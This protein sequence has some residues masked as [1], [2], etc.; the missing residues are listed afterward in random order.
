MQTHNV[1]WQVSLSNGETL[2]EDPQFGW[3]EL[4]KY[5]AQKDAT[6]T[7]LTLLADGRTFNLPSAGNN[8]KFK[9]FTDAPKPL[10]YRVSRAIGT[11]Y[12]N[13]GG[14]KRITDHFTIGI[15]V[16]NDYELQI[17]VDENNCKNSWGQVIPK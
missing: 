4:M 11:E 5:A 16:Y 17:W 15:A 9:Y 12:N 14:D 3:Q 7:S 8:P 10:G 2:S 1:I 13:V 6:I